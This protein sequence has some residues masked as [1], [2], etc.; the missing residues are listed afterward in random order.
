MKKFGENDIFYFDRDSNHY[1]IIKEVNIS[2]IDVI[3]LE[4]NPNFRATKRVIMPRGDE[5]DRYRITWMAC[6]MKQV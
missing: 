1:W 2:K 4:Y 3:T 6:T 5:F